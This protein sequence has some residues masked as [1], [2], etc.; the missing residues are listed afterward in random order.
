MLIFSYMHNTAG[1][2]VPYL[3]HLYECADALRD[4]PLADFLRRDDK[5]IVQ[6]KLVFPTQQDARNSP[7]R[8][9]KIRLTRPTDVAFYGYALG[10]AHTLSYLAV[11]PDFRRVMAIGA[12]AVTHFC[13]TRPHPLG[14]TY[15]DAI[16]S[17]VPFYR[18]LG[19]VPARE[20]PDGDFHGDALLVNSSAV[21]R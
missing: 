1:V 14:P 15:V 19:F 10:H 8:N 6:L 20:H 16:D 2:D 12:Y 9:Q 4:I 17:S 21:S 7:V 13:A 5:V 3:K 18:R 11:R